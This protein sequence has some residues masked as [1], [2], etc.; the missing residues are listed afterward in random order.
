[1]RRA[2][3]LAVVATL[4]LGCQSAPPSTPAP[5]LT[6]VSTQAI[7]PSP[8]I[9]PTPTAP[10]PSPEPTIDPG[11]QTIEDAIIET[12]RKRNVSVDIKDEIT[13]APGLDDGTVTA[14]GVASLGLPM[15]ISL[16]GDYTVAGLGKIEMIVDD[17][18]FYMRGK[19]LN[20]TVGKGNWLLID[21]NSTDPR[22]AAFRSVVE[23]Q[24]DMRLSIH[25]LWG[26]TKVEQLRSEAAGGEFGTFSDHY[27]VTVDLARSAFFAPESLQ[28][29]L[30]NNISALRFAGIGDRIVEDV[31]IGGDGVIHQLYVTFEFGASG[32]I[33]RQ[34]QFWNFGAALKLPIPRKADVVRLEDLPA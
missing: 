8:T 17:H 25:F 20:S 3:V 2:S 27:K 26:A 29:E 14:S 33:Q 10:A 34:Y 15:Q 18:L 30:F 9:L 12:V 31:W 1:M 22:A 13:D 5:T 23:G 24:N 4:V 32:R 19:T 21:T 28:H 6:A 16:K 7:A 11:V